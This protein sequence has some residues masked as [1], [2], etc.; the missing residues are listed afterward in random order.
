MRGQSYLSSV[1]SKMSSAIALVLVQPTHPAVL[2]GVD[3]QLEDPLHFPQLVMMEALWSP[4]Q[5]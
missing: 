1:Q 2:L 4:S 5:P 3:P